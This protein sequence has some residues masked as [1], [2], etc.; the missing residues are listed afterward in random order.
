MRDLMNSIH[1]VRALSPAAAIT[2][3]TAQVSQWVDRRGYDSVTFVILTGSL[4]DSD[5]TFAV[6]MEDADADNQSDA[7]AVTSG[8]LLGTLALAGFTFADDNET[9][10]IGYVGDKRFVRITITPSA[11]SGNAFLAA[12]AILGHPQNAAT[13]NPPV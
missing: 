12:T 10:K 3:N 9:R 2:D 4:A 7:A 13:P 8:D 1:P 5:A 11:N 6:T